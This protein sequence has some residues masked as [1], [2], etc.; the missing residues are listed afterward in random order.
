MHTVCKLYNG[1][2]GATIKVESVGE[3]GKARCGCGEG[4]SAPLH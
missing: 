4:G 3:D 1:A 2:R